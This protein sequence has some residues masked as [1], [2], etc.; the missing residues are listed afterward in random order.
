M[1]IFFGV[2]ALIQGG[3]IDYHDGDAQRAP[4]DRQRADSRSLSLHLSWQVFALSWWPLLGY[5]FTILITCSGNLVKNS[6][7]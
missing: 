3:A 7:L 5:Y 2:V 6:Q 4:E 1:N